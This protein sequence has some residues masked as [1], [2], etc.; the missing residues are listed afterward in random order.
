M[1]NRLEA[2][3]GQHVF[4]TSDDLP[5]NAAGI[6]AFR[7]V[8]NPGRLAVMARFCGVLNDRGYVDDGH[9]TAVFSKRL[10]DATVIADDALVTVQPLRWE[11]WIGAGGKDYTVL[12]V[13]SAYLEQRNKYFL[14]AGCVS[15]FP[16]YRPHITVLA[17]TPLPKS[18][19]R[20]ANNA[21]LLLRER[22]IRLSGELF[23]ELSV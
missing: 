10:P 8:I 21:L 20:V 2:K 16:Q 7:Q 22:E 23:N 4:T 12:L 17:G 1:G 13:Q 15:E 5:E 11:S 19:L 3:V 9:V 6:Y 18:S 14:S